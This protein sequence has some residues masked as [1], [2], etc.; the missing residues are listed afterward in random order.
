MPDDVMLVQPDA[1]RYDVTSSLLIVTNN[2]LNLDFQ[3][4]I[5][6]N[7]SDLPTEIFN[8]AQSAIINFAREE[9]SSTRDPLARALET[10]HKNLTTKSLIEL[11]RKS[12]VEKARSG[13]VR[14]A[15]NLEWF[16][17]ESINFA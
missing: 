15:G 12:V 8:N 1:W 3:S 16:V 4:K 7:V 2:L 9:K 14:S 17:I 10:H 13:W 5:D 11:F 6:E